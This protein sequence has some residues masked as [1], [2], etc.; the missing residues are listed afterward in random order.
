MNRRDFLR[1]LSL[2]TAATAA[3]LVV[4][5][6]EPVRRY[7]AVPRNAPVRSQW[8]EMADEFDALVNG[9]PLRSDNPGLIRIWVE[10]SNV[11]YGQP[12]QLQFIAGEVIEPGELVALDHRGLAFRA[13]TE[14]DGII[15]GPMVTWRSPGAGQGAH[16]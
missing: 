10:S 7:W 12:M 14:P 2:G 9:E 11:F 4:P 13:K 16:L 1:L 8:Q 15:V 3:G 5:T 6:L